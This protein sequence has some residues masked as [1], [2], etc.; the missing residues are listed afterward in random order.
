MKLTNNKDLSAA[1]KERKAALA[2]RKPSAAS[3]KKEGERK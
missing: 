3:G 2:A 1:I